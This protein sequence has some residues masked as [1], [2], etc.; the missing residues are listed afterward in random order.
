MAPLPLLSIEPS[1]HDTMGGG[2]T[3]ARHSTQHQGSESGAA[4]TRIDAMEV[5][6][7]S[8]SADCVVVAPLLMLARLSQF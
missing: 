7:V 8:P 2:Q 5:I 3:N 6:P 1:E 4:V